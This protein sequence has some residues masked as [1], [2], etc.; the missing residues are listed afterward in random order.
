LTDNTSATEG[1]LTQDE[2]PVGKAVK[3]VQYTLTSADRA[4]APSGWVLQGSTDGTSWR[5]L[6]KR[7]GESFAYDQQTR[8][9]SVARPG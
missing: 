2:L 4:K 3:A 1:P 7:G 6:D 5:D 8:V 9:F